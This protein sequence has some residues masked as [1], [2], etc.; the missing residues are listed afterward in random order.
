VSQGRV[1]L[2]QTESAKDS[3]HYHVAFF[4][5]IATRVC[6]IPIAREAQTSNLQAC[7]GC[8]MRLAQRI[9]AE[10]ATTKVV[11]Y[12]SMAWGYTVVSDLVLPSPMR[13]HQLAVS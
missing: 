1:P 4:A 9:G 12:A 13:W 8:D 3:G 2:S 10:L 7:R 5:E 6:G 11:P